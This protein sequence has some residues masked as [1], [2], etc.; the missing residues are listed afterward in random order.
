MQSLVAPHIIRTWPRRSSGRAG[1]LLARART[2]RGAWRA[3][4]RSASTRV[5]VR[6]KLI[7][8]GLVVK[9]LIG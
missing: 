2:L 4:R 9:R 3:G 8:F 5:V 7:P 1:R 6:Q